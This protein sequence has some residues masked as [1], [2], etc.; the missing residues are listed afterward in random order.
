MAR[1]TSLRKKAYTTDGNNHAESSLAVISAPNSL[2][3]EIRTRA[4]LLYEQEGRQPGHDEEYWLRAESEILER[5]GGRR[6]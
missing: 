6:D 1:S 5:H 2:E 3:D 4:Y